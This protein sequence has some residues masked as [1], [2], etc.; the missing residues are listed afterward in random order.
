[1]IILFMNELIKRIKSDNIISLSILS[2]LFLIILSLALSLFFYSKLPP[3]LPLFNQM[4]WGETRLAQKQDIFL[5]PAVSFI[6]FATNSFLA[7]LL[8]NRMPLLSRMLATTSL[9]VSILSFLLIVRTIQ[10][11]L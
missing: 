11:M 9:L 2:G 1:M 7:S 4:P 6:I 10:I 3:V 8:Y 5:L